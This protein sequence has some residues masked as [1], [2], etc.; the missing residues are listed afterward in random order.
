MRFLS[1]SNEWVTNVQVD[2]RVIIII[3]NLRRG[4]IQWLS[5]LS[6]DFIQHL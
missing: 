5:E 2:Y 3:H 6:T 4:H 1:K